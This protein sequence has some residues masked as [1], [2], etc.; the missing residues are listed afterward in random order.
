MIDATAAAHAGIP[1]DRLK[2]RVKT[3]ED[4]AV[5]VAETRGE[6]AGAAERAALANCQSLTGP[7][8][9][10]LAA[11]QSILRLDGVPD[12]RRAIEK[13]AQACKDKLVE[14]APPLI[15]VIT[16]TAGP[17]DGD[18]GTTTGGR[19]DPVALQNCLCA[20]NRGKTEFDCSYDT[21]DK[22]W[23]PSCR[24][25]DNGPCICKAFGCYRAQPVTSGAC[26]I[27]CRAKYGGGG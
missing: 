9:D 5:G 23:S 27:A 18:G 14:D 3:I 1:W 15:P 13:D 22:G 25:L 21:K 26:A 16:S 4:A 8:E 12:R 20:C 10:Q 7:F 17:S 6:G 2:T 24:N 19:S 11:M